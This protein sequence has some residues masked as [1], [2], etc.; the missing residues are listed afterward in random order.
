MTAIVSVVHFLPSRLSSLL[1]DSLFT[2]HPM[3]NHWWLPLYL[4]LIFSRATLTHRHCW[5]TI[6]DDVLGLFKLVLCIR[7]GS[8]AVTS[9]VSRP[10]ITSI[11]SQIHRVRSREVGVADLIVEN[12]P[13]YNY[14]CQY[15]VFSAVNILMP[16]LSLLIRCL[17]VPPSRVLFF[18][19]RF[20]FVIDLVSLL[21]LSIVSSSSSCGGPIKLI[22]S[23][24]TPH[25]LLNH[26]W[27]PL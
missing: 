5:L 14:C 9:L 18:L 11:T 27:L 21:C 7:W 1:I 22:D 16:C 6:F 3:L 19:H 23:L 15:Q 12:P 17:L 13:I 26:W 24:F 2:P 10:M 25:P 20:S 4:L 8:Y